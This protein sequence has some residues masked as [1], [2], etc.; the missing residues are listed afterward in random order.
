[1]FSGFFSVTTSAVS[2]LS[3]SLTAVRISVSSSTTKIEAFF[4]TMEAIYAIS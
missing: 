1:M 3:K 4:K 2:V